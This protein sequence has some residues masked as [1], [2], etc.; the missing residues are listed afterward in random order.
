MQDLIPVR[1]RECPDG[2]HPDG[3][4]VFILPKLSLEGG[5]AARQD[6]TFV[7]E[8]YPVGKD[9]I[10]AEGNFVTDA[11]RA[12]DAALIRA[13]MVTFCRYGAVSW[14][15]HD[16]DGPVWPFS[17][18]RL[19]EDGELGYIVADVADDHYRAAVMRPLLVTVQTTSRPGA[20]ASPST[21]PRTTSTGPR[22]R[23]SSRRASAGRQSRA[24]TA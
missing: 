6:M 4:H 19:L 15:L 5:I 10:D 11:G 18:D 13:W 16:P 7:Q 14:E 8:R 1:V 2:T 9:D 23:S 3:D 17:V 21:P 12:Y 22:R 24:R 20:G